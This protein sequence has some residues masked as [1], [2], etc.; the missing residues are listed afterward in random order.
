MKRNKSLI[1]LASLVLLVTVTVTGTLAYLVDTDGPITNTFTPS[2]VDN[3][4]EEETESGT[5]N[6][7]TVKNTGD[8]AS[9]IRAAV[10]VTWVSETDSNDILP[11]A[12]SDYQI[13]YPDNTGWIKSGGYYYYTTAVAP[14]YS[15]GILFT[16]CK[17]LAEK[18]GYQLSVEIMAQSIQSV[19][20]DAVKEAWD[21][22]VADDG[23]ISN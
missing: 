8:V 14:G 17:P 18:D 15:T 12:S 4:I 7:V 19:P 13:T 1:L 10:V 6:N 22:T 5:K 20:T 16:N 3:E 23:S 2:K 9:Y 11:A 21:V